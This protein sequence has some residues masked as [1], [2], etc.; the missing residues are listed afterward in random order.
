MNNVKRLIV[1]EQL[2]QW[3]AEGLVERSNSPWSSPVVIVRKKDFTFRLCG[4]YRKLNS[5]TIADQYP[6]PRIDEILSRLGKAK[7]FTT[8]DMYH[9]YQEF[10]M[11]EEDKAKTAFQTPRGLWQFKVMQLWATE[12]SGHLSAPDG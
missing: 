12:R 3:I 11:A 4:D 6:M 7:Y 9:S 5:V 8:L 2:N 10:E 1:E